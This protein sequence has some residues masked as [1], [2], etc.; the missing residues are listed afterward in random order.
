MEGL[1]QM[2]EKK[3][4]HCCLGG[5]TF[6][7]RI[8]F[9]DNSTWQGTICWLNGEKCQTF[10]SLLEMISLIKEAVEMDGSNDAELRTWENAEESSP[11][12]NY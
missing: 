5:E 1:K 12:R 8:Q 7:I 6:L 9:R 3:E 4:Y 2:V 11:K 10:R